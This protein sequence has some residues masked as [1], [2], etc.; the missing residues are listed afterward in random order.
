MDFPF[1]ALTNPVLARVVNRALDRLLPSK[2][3]SALNGAVGQ[4]IKAL[5]PE[6]SGTVPASVLKGLHPGAG[7]ENVAADSACWT[8]VHDHLERKVVPPRDVW[9]AALQ[10]RW[11]HVRET[12][13]E[14][15]AIFG[16]DPAVLEPLLRDLS[17]KLEEACIG[18]QELLGGTIYHT[19]ASV[20]EMQKQL[21]EVHGA[22]AAIPDA[23]LELLDAEISAAKKLIEQHDHEA[24][25]TILEKIRD[26]AKLS[27]PQKCRTLALLANTYIKDGNF[28]EAGKLLLKAKDYDPNDE[29]AQINEALGLE[30][31]QNTQG[32]HELAADLKVRYPHSPAAWSIWTRTTPSSDAVAQVV[33]QIPAHILDEAEVAVAVALVALR[34]DSFDTAVANA[35]KAAQASPTWPASWVML[36]QSLQEKAWSSETAAQDRI[37]LLRDA[38]EAHSKAA[39]LAAGQKNRAAEADALFNRSTVRDVIGEAD[40]ASDC[41]KAWKLTPDN[42][43]IARRHAVFV[44]DAER[45]GEAVPLAEAAMAL[46]PG[47]GT[48][49][50][51]AACLNGRNQPPDRDEALK[52]CREVVLRDEASEYTSE[53]IH[54]ATTILAERKEY[55]EAK[56]FLQSAKDRLSSVAS[57]TVRARIMLAE[58]DRQAAINTAEAVCSVAADTS[59][60]EKHRLAWFLVQLGCNA[61]AVEILQGVIKPGIFDSHMRT[62]LD[63]AQRAGR[64]DVY[65]KTVKE[66]R[67]AGVE[68]DKLLHNEIALLRLYDPEQAVRV[69]REFL[70]RNPYHKRA[71]LY[72][73]LLGVMLRRPD[74][75]CS[76]LALLP[77]VEDCDPEEGGAWTVLVLIESGRL[78]LALPYAY[79]M[80]RRHPGDIAAHRAYMCVF[81]D[82]RVRERG[83]SILATPPRVAPGCAVE[84]EEELSDQ[85]T[86]WV[87]IED[88]APVHPELHEFSP[89]HPISAALIGRTVGETVVLSQDPI[90]CR[91]ARILQVKNKYVH[92]YHRCLHEFQLLFQD[93][94]DVRVFHVRTG[95]DTSDSYDFST[96]EKALR[97]QQDQI[98]KSLELYRTHPVPLQMLADRTGRHIFDVL[99]FLASEPKQGIICC[100]GRLEEREAA[101]SY[102]SYANELVIDATGIFSLTSLERI[103]LLAKWPTRPIVSLSTRQLLM[104]LIKDRT[105]RPREHTIALTRTGK[106][107]VYGHDAKSIAAYTAKLQRALDVIDQHCQV[108]PCE[109]L[110]SVEPT[111]REHLVDWFGQHG[112]ESLVLAAQPGRLFWTDDYVL[113]LLGK[114]EFGINRVWTQVALNAAMDLKRLEPQEFSKDSAKLFASRYTSTYW[115]HETLIAGALLCNWDLDAWPLKGFIDEF[116]NASP[117]FIMFRIALLAMKAVYES[118]APAREKNG[119]IIRVMNRLSRTE[120]PL[121]VY[122]VMSYA[123]R[124][125][126]AGDKEL[127]RHIQ[128]VLDIWYG[129]YKHE[130][131]SVSE[132]FVVPDALAEGN[133]PAT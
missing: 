45:F 37:K 83:V 114:G 88:N 118:A 122:R 65:L 132:A 25:R 68:D 38:I 108:L 79:Q 94:P 96:L 129:W 92:R 93:E 42:P 33:K 39:V 67:E 35:R 116:S 100:S 109:Q 41:E 8:S 28:K 99:G 6:F 12:V 128:T 102:V 105:E 76:D 57:E 30:L 119:L 64:D 72:L 62:L 29:K 84:L 131:I 50:F 91:Q 54:L 52:L 47:P 32:A 20:P 46:N 81:F 125:I 113:G 23:H 11:A 82:R 5:A 110:A 121:I 77:R 74:L 34:Q 55:E 80:L 24:A 36:G 61:K 112:A 87:T 13:A 3:M 43:A 124:K 115:N 120:M 70:K 117:D 31:L 2:L 60:T 111:K 66:L 16:A 19:L 78:D 14:P 75:V 51:L 73:S 7:V 86:R 130:R 1:A 27:A 63:C 69:L 53:A 17:K 49:L 26:T 48:R 103:D 89:E 58:G 15:E 107:T 133:P 127:V 126:C 104:T 9:Y 98:E 4:W 90:Q 85:P 101:Y 106:L 97:L 95:G 59:W 123:I 56:T 71:H 40:A 21:A 10:R 22:I 18:Q 44:A